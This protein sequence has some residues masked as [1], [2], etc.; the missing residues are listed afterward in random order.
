MDLRICPQNFVGNFSEEFFLTLFWQKILQK[1]FRMNLFW[2]YF[3]PFLYPTW[4]S[5][6]IK[7]DPNA[8][9]S[10]GCH[11]LDHADTWVTTKCVDGWSLT[12]EG[13]CITDCPVGAFLFGGECVDCTPN[14]NVCFGEWDFQCAECNARYSLNFQQ[15]CSFKCDLG[16]GL[17]GSPENGE[18]CNTCDSSCRTC[19]AGE[20]VSCTQCPATQGGFTYS[21]RKFLYAV[22][23]TEAGYCLRDPSIDYQNFFRQYP[24][25][26]VIVECPDG[27]S[28]CIDRYHC[29]ACEFGYSLYPPSSAGAEYALCYE[30]P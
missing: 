24:N 14:C 15:I 23:R 30:D 5:N 7:C 13:T 21:L 29:T 6:V 26:L 16:G 12:V 27:C 20:Q 4:S 3:V 2:T 9:M 17:Y 28:T 8:S 22:G 1:F 11:L 18:T 19:F 25:D 10:G